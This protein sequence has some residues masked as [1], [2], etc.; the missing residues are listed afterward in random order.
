MNELPRFA[1]GTVQAKAQYQPLLI[2]LL[3]QLR[4]AG[5][6]SQV[7]LS[8]SQ[9]LATDLFRPLAGRCVRH[10]DSWLMTAE[11]CRQSFRL[12]SQTADVSLVLGTYT[13]ASSPRILGSGGTLDALVDWLT[14]PRVVLLDVSRLT[15]RNGVDLPPKTAGLLLSG[16]SSARQYAAWGR[17]LERDTRVPVLGGLCGSGSSTWPGRFPQRRS[18][19]E[20]VCRLADDLS[21]HLDLAG[22]TAVAC[23]NP[24]PGPSQVA[25]VYPS[26]RRGLGVAIALDKAFHAYYPDVLDLLELQGAALRVFSPLKTE[27]LPPN[28]DLVLLGGGVPQRYAKRLAANVCL[29]Q[30]LR[31]HVRAGGRVYA[32]GGGLAYICRALQVHGRVFP[33]AGLLPAVAVYEPTT[34]RPVEL[35]LTHASWLCGQQGILRGYRN[36]DWQLE[37][38]GPLIDLADDPQHDLD[39][40]GFRQVIGSR[41]HVQFSAQPAL[42]R[43]LLQPFPVKAR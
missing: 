32:E 40:V 17:R 31:E 4:R 11:T 30:S 21:R 22:L 29:K 18:R 15:L 33:M 13:A 6:S 28:T 5:L 10:L 23:Q 9:F 41:V 34:A 27:Q 16:V 20:V 12:G 43:N 3:E 1:L 38:A 7:Y 24:W 2:A 19:C 36:T 42:M 35:H 14:L 25:T 8:R 37:T 26:H 39:L